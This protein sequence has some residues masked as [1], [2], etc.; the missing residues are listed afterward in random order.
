MSHSAATAWVRIAVVV[1]V[2]LAVVGAVLAVSAGHAGLW[3]ASGDALLALTALYFAAF[4]WLVVPEQVD[5]PVVWTMTAFAFFGG[6]TV[7]GFATA[8]VLVSDSP[9]LVWGVS[10][11]PADLPPAAAWILV[12]TGWGWVGA[13]LPLL[14]F[15][16]LLFPDGTLPSPRWRWVGVLA[17]LGLVTTAAALVWGYRPQNTGPAEDGSLINAGLALVVLAALLSFAALVGRFRSSTGTRRQQLKWILWG[18]GVLVGVM[19]VGIVLALA[20]SID[21]DLLFVPWMAAVSVFVVSYGFAVGRYR[22]YDVDLVIK[23][24]VVYTIVVAVLAGMFVAG[25]IWIP[26]LL[27]TGD[28][29]IAVAATTLVVLFLFQPLRRRVQVE[30]ER[31]LY[32]SRYDAQL[33]ADEFA[34]RLRDEVDPRTVAGDWAAVVNETMHPKTLSIWIR[35]DLAPTPGE[36]PVA[37]TQQRAH[38]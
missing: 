18:S 26:S 31:R 27:P 34:G 21:T 30:V 33:V 32:R 25:T 38:T 35:N 5:N 20:G 6:L 8:A 11:I 28:N 19:L 10:V 9:G 2:A 1:G 23:R 12:I 4:V 13:L 24:T 15:G 37:P 7:A 22:L 36:Q 29:S 3:I 14:T 17:T 16:L